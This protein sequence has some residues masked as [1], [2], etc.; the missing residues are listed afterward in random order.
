MLAVFI[1][2]TALNVSNHAL[3]SVVADLGQFRS[4]ITNRAV[5]SLHGVVHELAGALDTA[6]TVKPIAF[7]ADAHDLAVLTQNLVRGLQEVQVQAARC[8]LLALLL[9]G[10]PGGEGLHHGL[11][12]VI[13][14]NSLIRSLVEL[15]VLFVE[16][17]I[18]IAG[19]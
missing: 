4:E 15:E 7:H 2:H 17:N 12:L 6:L 10:K 13:R 16:H 5:H 9:V 19:V 3:I 8:G 11:H 14:L 18:D 1:D